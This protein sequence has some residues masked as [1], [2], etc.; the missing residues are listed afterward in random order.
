MISLPGMLNSG[1]KV[2]YVSKQL[3]TQFNGFYRTLGAKYN[4]L[5]CTRGRHTH[6]SSSSIPS[7][8]A[9]LNLPPGVSFKKTFPGK[10]IK[11]I[12][13]SRS[14]NAANKALRVLDY[15]GTVTFAVGGTITAGHAG[16]DMLGCTMV[17]TITAVGGGTV[18]DI[19]LGQLPV[20]WTI[21]I[22]Y[23]LMCIAAGLTTF[24]LYV[25]SDIKSDNGIAVR[26]PVDGMYS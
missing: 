21:E 12:P 8:T 24:F 4:T 2:S 5:R 23:I 11:V 26:R 20:F 17:G 6:A 15:I 3:R 19:L 16:L 13:P 9:K 18:R 25:D 7:Q 22:E 10:T 1:Y 14:K